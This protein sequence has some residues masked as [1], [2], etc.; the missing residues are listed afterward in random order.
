MKKDFLIVGQGIS[1]TVIAQTIESFGL[2]CVIFDEN[3]KTTSSNV[4][5]GIMNPI[6][7]KRCTLSWRGQE[8]SHYSKSFYEKLDKSLKTQNFKSIPLIRLFSSFEEQNN[9]IGKSGSNIYK[10]HLG[11]ESFKLNNIINQ[12]GNGEVKTAYHLNV[13]SFIHSS[14]KFFKTKT[15][16]INEAFETDK[17]KKEE[18]LF[19]YQGI[20]AKYVIMCEGVNA[21]KNKLFNNIPIIPNKGELLEIEAK[22][23]PNII[24]SKGIFTLPTINNNFTIGST[25]DHVD[26]SQIITQK[27]KNELLNKFKKITN[28]NDFKV[29]NQKYGFRPTTI[30]RKP[31]IGQHLSIRNLFIFNGMGSKAVLMAPLLAK[32]LIDHIISNKK[33]DPVINS[34]RFIKK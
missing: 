7:L 32:E 5:A 29:I 12:Y 9:W 33:L 4:A 14:K 3:I 24:L 10:N 30:D 15:K 1:G 22:Q 27:A 11:S 28:S 16:L 25:Y 21:A 20:S 18:G 19:N 2:S 34:S 8:F 26:S 17:L 23:L 13:K 6:S 31:I